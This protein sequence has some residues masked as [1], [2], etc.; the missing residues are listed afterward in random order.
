MPAFFKSPAAP[1]GRERIA[2]APRPRLR[3]EWR[4]DATGRLSSRWI[5][6][7]R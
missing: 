4:L 7:G 1:P 2:A 6:A 3:L 5:A